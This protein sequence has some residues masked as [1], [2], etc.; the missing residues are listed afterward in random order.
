MQNI[1]TIIEKVPVDNTAAASL[2]QSFQIHSQVSFPPPHGLSILGS[3]V[4]MLIKR[5]PEPQLAQL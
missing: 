3:I 1:A 5:Q 2:P 4:L